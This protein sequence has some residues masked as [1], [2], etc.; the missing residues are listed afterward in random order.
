[1]KISAVVVTYNR[2]EYLKKCLRAIM[3]QTLKIDEI[4]VINNK[5]TDSTEAWLTEFSAD[6]PVVKATTLPQNAGGAGG[7]EAGM[8][9]AVENGA[10]YVWIMDDDTL[11]SPTALEV[12]VRECQNDPKVG[13]ACSRVEWT[14]G[15]IHEM[16]IPKFWDHNKLRRFI[17]QITDTTEC[18]GASFVSLLVPSRAVY[19]VGLPIGEFFIWHDDI[20]FTERI[21]HAGYKG[22]YVPGSIVTH[23]TARNYGASI[24]DA[25][26]SI[27]NR[28]YYQIRNQ[29]VTKRMRTNWLVARISNRLRV[30]RVK[31]ALRRRES[32]RQIFLEQVLRGYRD[33][34]RFRPQIKYPNPPHKS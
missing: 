11:P 28:F 30:R 4:I 7:F 25:P 13:F 9:T 34:L 16:N 12:L 18:Q 33:G 29:M 5:S 14:D 3:A 19:Q 10:D 27:A 20:E 26:V 21:T 15:N 31:R 23:A 6:N 8:K 24:I 2:L 1:M 17:T 32:D 22:I